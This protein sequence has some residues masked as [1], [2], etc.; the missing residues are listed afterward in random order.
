MAKPFIYY[1]FYPPFHWVQ[2]WVKWALNRF[3]VGIGTFRE[4]LAGFRVVWNVR[5]A[6][7]SFNGFKVVILSRESRTVDGHPVRTWVN[8]SKVL[9]SNPLTVRFWGSLWSLAIG[10]SGTG[11][12]GRYLTQICRALSTQIHNRTRKLHQIQPKP[13][14]N[15]LKLTKMNPKR[16]QKQP[17]MGPEVSNESFTVFRLRCIFGL[18]QII[19]INT[20]Y[21]HTF[22]FGQ[23]VKLSLITF[24]YSKQSKC[25]CIKLQKM[26]KMEHMEFL[27]LILLYLIFILNP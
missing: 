13:T 4:G 21:F 5:R 6:L 12:I 7:L 17:K 18:G 9:A 15:D 14:Q 19:S 22:Q 11:L 16:T 8:R 3:R 10:E 2:S 25:T 1:S 24:Y 23:R 27:K 26:Q 20:F